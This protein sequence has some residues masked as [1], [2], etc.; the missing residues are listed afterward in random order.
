MHFDHFFS[1]AFFAPAGKLCLLRL[2]ANGIPWVLAQVQT[3]GYRAEK[4]W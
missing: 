3:I 2:H 4:N 1:L